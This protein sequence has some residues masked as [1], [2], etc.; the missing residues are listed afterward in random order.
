MPIYR[1][2]FYLWKKLRNLCH[3]SDDSDTSTE[4]SS[5]STSLSRKSS[6]LEGKINKTSISRS[7]SFTFNQIE[8]DEHRSYATSEIELDSIQTICRL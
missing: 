1:W 7:D 5:R 3:K 4:E 2:G 6:K 8:D